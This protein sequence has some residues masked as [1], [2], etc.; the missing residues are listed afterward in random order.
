MEVTELI[1]YEP[2]EKADDFY[3]YHVKAKLLEQYRINTET[4]R[5]KFI[6]H[7]QVQ[8]SL[9]KDLFFELN[10]YLGGWLCVLQVTEFEHLKNPLVIS[11]QTTCFSWNERAFY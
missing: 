3:F 10:S 7:Q 5:Q 4:Y 2:A 9:W 6:Q 11:D 8:G 1:L